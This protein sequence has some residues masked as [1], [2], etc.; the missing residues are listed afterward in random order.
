MKIQKNCIAILVSAALIVTGCATGEQHRAD[1]YTA[2]QVNT[3]Q[4][5]KPVVILALNPAK[6]QVDNTEGKRKAQIGGAVAGA[7]LGGAAGGT[8]KS[9]SGANVAGGAATGGIVGA[10]AGSMVDDK[11]LVDGVSIIFKEDGKGKKPK[12]STQVGKICEFK[13]G[14]AFMFMTKSNETRIQPNNPGG[15]NTEKK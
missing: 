11:I 7:L 4:D 12:T 3:A 9:K 10:A 8:A 14:D 13:V 1:S 2:D 15:C 5:V 6:V